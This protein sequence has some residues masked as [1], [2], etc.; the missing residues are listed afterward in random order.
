M[1]ILAGKITR[2][3]KTFIEQTNIQATFTTF[4]LKL[5]VK[6]TTEATNNLNTLNPKESMSTKL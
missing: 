6:V 1:D 2:I 5:N 3:E 4:I